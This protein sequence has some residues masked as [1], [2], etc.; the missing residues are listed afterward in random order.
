MTLFV[1]FDARALGSQDDL[2]LASYRLESARASPINQLLFG[3]EWV[4]S[5]GFCDE[6]SKR[7]HLM[8]LHLYGNSGMTVRDVIAGLGQRDAYGELH[9]LDW[10]DVGLD[11]AI[12]LTR[13]EQAWRQVDL[14]TKLSSVRLPLFRG[15]HC[16]SPFDGERGEL[17][18]LQSWARQVAEKGRRDGTLKIDGQSGEPTGFVREVQVF[19]STVDSWTPSLKVATHWS[20][21]TIPGNE[22]CMV[23]AAGVAHDAVVFWREDGLAGDEVVVLGGTGTANVYFQRQLKTKSTQEELDT[24]EP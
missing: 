24:M 2:R 17:S 5:N 8:Y 1:P 9:N 12:E 14:A 20:S 19:T 6:P 16:M 4:A 13:E 11:R 7:V 15:V 3:H 23:M 10:G 22:F 18:R 21:T